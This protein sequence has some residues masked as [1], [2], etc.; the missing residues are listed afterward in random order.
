MQAISL[1]Y[2]VHDAGH[3]ILVALRRVQSAAVRSAYT[4]APGRTEEELRDLIKVRYAASARDSGS[5]DAWLLHCATREGIKLRAQRPDGKLVFGGRQNLERRRKGLIT[6][7]DWRSLRLRPL[8]SIGDKGEL[9]NRHFRLSEDARTCT[10]RVYGHAVV[11]ALP[12]MRGKRGELLRAVAALTAAGEINVEFR[13]GRDRLS[14]IFD[15]ADLRRLPAGVTLQQDDDARLAAKGHKPRG[16]PRG[17]GWKPPPFRWADVERPVHPEWGPAI[18]AL[19]G[20]CLGIDLNPGWIG[21]TVV[22]N[23]GNLRSLPATHVLDH[24]LV[25]LDLPRGASPELVTETLAKVAGLAVGLCEMHGVGFVSMEEGLGKLRSGGRSKATNHRLNSWDRT[26]LKAMLARRLGLREAS[27]VT[28]WAAYSTTIGNVVFA[29]PDAC[30]AAAD[31]GRRGLAE[32]DWRARTRAARLNGSLPKGGVEK[33]LL[34]FPCPEALPSLWKD[35]DMPNAAVQARLR[36][37]GTWQAVHREIKSAAIGVRR[38]HPELVSGADGHARV[39]GPGHAVSRLGHRRRPGLVLRPTAV[40]R[41]VQPG[42]A[43]ATDSRE[44]R[45]SPQAAR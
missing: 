11:L 30:A 24:R 25:R 8:V 10:L 3:E 36:Q 7:G 44:A 1:P 5:V 45:V 42:T 14:V 33:D 13:L 16:R 38:P 15:P 37:A 27:L 39:S 19:P 22:E 35:S 9:G 17:E 43:A 2:D 18:T 32:V 20:R 26:R 31:I 12:E 41:P 21:L 6:A 40:K 34:P 23:R 4:N 28:V 29:L